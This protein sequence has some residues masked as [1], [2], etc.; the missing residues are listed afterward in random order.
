MRIGSRIRYLRK[1][2]RLRQVDLAEKVG[3]TSATLVNIEKARH[4]PSIRLLCVI[5][6]TLG[7][8]A[9]ALIDEE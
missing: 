5:A 9:G 1:L 7:V 8:P 6:R 2:K 4:A 3:I